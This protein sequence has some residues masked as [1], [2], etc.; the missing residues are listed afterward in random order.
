MHHR[1]MQRQYEVFHQKRHQGEGPK[2]AWIENHVKKNFS[3][4][5]RKTLAGM[6]RRAKL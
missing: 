6:I 1:M 4:E 2:M 5:E 3:E